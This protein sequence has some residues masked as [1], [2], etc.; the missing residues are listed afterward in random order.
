MPER[1]VT[2]HP[3]VRNDG[4]SGR[5]RQRR[6]TA[7]TMSGRDCGKNRQSAQQC[8]GPFGTRRILLSL[9][10]LLQT[11][12]LFIYF[13]FFFCPFYRRVYNFFFRS[14]FHSL[15]TVVGMQIFPV[16][17]PVSNHARSWQYSYLLL[18]PVH[19]S[20]STTIA[21]VMYKR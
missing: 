11:F 3:P 4:S 16:H 6:A 8:P 5:R 7:V 13:F 21:I 9:F 19:L 10:Y 18:L 15:L 20:P 14:S 2:D 1:N 12:Y 17:A